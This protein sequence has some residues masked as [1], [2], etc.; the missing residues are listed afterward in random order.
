VRSG[1]SIAGARGGGCDLRRSPE[2]RHHERGR[3]FADSPLEGTGFEPSVPPRKRRPSREAPR[4][5]IVVSRDDL[6]LMTPSNL[7]VRHHSS[8]TAERPFTRAGP[9][10]RIRFP[11]AASPTLQWTLRLRA[12]SPRFRGAPVLRFRIAPARRS[13]VPMPSRGFLPRGLSTPAHRAR[14]GSFVGAVSGVALA[15]VEQGPQHRA[16]LFALFGQYIFGARRVLL[17]K[18]PLDDPGFLQPL[19]S[20]R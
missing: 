6:R 4:P 3:K 19:Q 1:G 12:E 17:V 11:P 14:L 15:P 18:P 10:V 9:M 2:P 20:R 7:S 8:A 5:T 16:Q 13:V